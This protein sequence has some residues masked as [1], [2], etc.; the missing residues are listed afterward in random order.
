MKLQPALGPDPAQAVTRSL[1]WDSA[2]LKIPNAPEA[3]RFLDYH[4]REGWTL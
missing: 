2:N 3:E 1:D 4:Y